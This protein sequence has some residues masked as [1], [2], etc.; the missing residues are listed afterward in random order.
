ML[1]NEFLDI[2]KSRRSV[3][4]F[5][6]EQVSD[7]E[8]ELLLEAARFAPSNSNRQAWKFLIVKNLDVKKKMALAVGDK[9]AEIKGKLIDPDLIQSFDSYAQYLTFFASAPV[10]I[11]VLYKRS[12]SFL[13]NLFQKLN[14]PRFDEKLSPELMSVSMA[15]QNLQLMVHALKLGSCCMTGPLIAA[16]ELKTILDVRAPFELA[17][18]IP[19]GRTNQSVPPP[20]RKETGAISEFME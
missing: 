15:I 12:S 20:E 6:Q 14:L 9:A 4:V 19:V 8:I 2:L 17:A 5:T 7:E 3:R 1:V 18:L 16:R 10:V 13:E 11:V